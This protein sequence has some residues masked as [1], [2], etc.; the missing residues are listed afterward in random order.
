MKQRNFSNFE[1]ALV[2]AGIELRRG[3]R[4]KKSLQQFSNRM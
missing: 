3:R 2:R 1:A 4:R